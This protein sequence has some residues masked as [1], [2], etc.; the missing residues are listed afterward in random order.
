MSFA[1]ALELAPGRSRRAGPRHAAAAAGITLELVET[2]QALRALAPEWDALFE[3]AGRP[4]QVF[5]T[6][7]FAE[8][9]A[10][11]YRDDGRPR[12]AIVTGRQDGRL[13]LVCPFV[14]ERS[15][16]LNVLAWLGAPIAQYGDVLVEPGPDA[17]AMLSAAWEHVRTHVR[18]DVVRLR[19]VRAD[20]AVSPLLATISDFQSCQEEAASV[21]LGPCSRDA[22]STASF[23]DRQSSKA[24][25]NR[26]RLLR[27]LEEQGAVCF[28]ALEP[29]QLARARAAAGLAMKRRWLDARGLYSAAFADRRIEQFFET[30]AADGAPDTGCRVFALTLD[31][32]PIAAAIGFVGQQRL[33]LH[34]IA[35]DLPHEKAGAGVLN[36]EAILRWAEAR[37]LTDVDLLAPKAD[38]KMD[39]ADATAS[40][41][42]HAAA[43]SV[44]GW[45]YVRAVDQLLKPLAKAAL[46]HLPVTLTRRIVPRAG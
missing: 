2:A 13:A 44:P 19:K 23:E 38:Y 41:C 8:A 36:L 18:P 27:R 20:A 25:K 34:M 42:D 14:V 6:H 30:T 37:G 29:S 33:T 1:Q 10:R 5:Q 43:T 26:R 3:R 22:S 46:A 11:T 17:P 4:T 24:R 12:L 35:Y 15:A 39:W 16:G 31:G 40:V 21:T 7:A 28:E 9:W 32:T 45:I